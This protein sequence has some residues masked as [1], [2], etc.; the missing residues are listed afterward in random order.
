MPIKL[1]QII[2]IVL[3]LVLPVGLFWLSDH[4]GW[5]IWWKILAMIVIVILVNLGFAVIAYQKHCQKDQS[6]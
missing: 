3:G 2:L 6:K 1:Q 5:P 4:Q